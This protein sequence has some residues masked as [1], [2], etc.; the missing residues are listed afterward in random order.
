M[1]VWYQYHHSIINAVSSIICISSIDI[2]NSYGQRFDAIGNRLTA[3]FHTKNC[4]T[5]NL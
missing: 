5:R 4:Q 1:C 2:N 3:I